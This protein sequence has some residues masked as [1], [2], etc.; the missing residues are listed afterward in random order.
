MKKIALALALA[1][2]S[3]VSFAQSSSV[4]YGIVDMGVSRNF[5]TG[6][7]GVD[8]GLQSGSRIGFRGTEDLGGGVSAIYALEAGFQADTGDFDTRY[9]KGLFNRQAYV[10]LSS[11]SMGTVKLGRQLAPIYNALYDVDPFQVGLAGS[12]TRL[13][14]DGG[15]SVSNTIDYSSSIG[16]LTGEVAYSFGEKSTSISDGRT[17]GAYTSA[18]LGLLSLHAAYNSADIGG[19]LNRTTLLGT[20]V[21]V[22]STIKAHG[23]IADNSIGSLK[24]RDYMVGVSAAATPVDTFMGSVI[25]KQDRSSSNVAATQY[26]IGWTHSLSKRTNLYTSY[27]QTKFDVASTDKVVNVGI[28]H[29]F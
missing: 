12:A 10:G 6:I 13:M 8:S 16:P 9:G 3:A 15:R 5:G 19:V 17:I 4:V 7:T 23:A 28:R 18:N 20:V 14:N 2:I 21:N 26:A 27:A 1:G 25:R 24:S 29:K 11:Q 22:T